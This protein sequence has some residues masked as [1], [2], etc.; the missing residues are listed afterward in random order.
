MNGTQRSRDIFNARLQEINNVIQFDE[1]KNKVGSE[2]A[3]AQTMMLPRSTLR[4]ASQRISTA[5]MPPELTFLLHS[6]TGLEFLH[7]L[8]VCTEFVI[9]QIAG[10]GIRVVQEFYDLLGIS[11]LIAT[12]IGSLQGRIASMENHIIEF[13][14]QQ[15]TSLAAQ[16]GDQIISLC[17]D[18]TY[19]DQ[20]CLVAIEPVSNFI[21]LES[22]SNKQD[23]ATWREHLQPRLSALNTTVFQTVGDEGS[24]LKS[25]A[26]NDLQAHHS[27]DLFHILQDVGRALGQ[28]FVKIAARLKK[29]YWRPKSIPK[30]L[31]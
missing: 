4:R 9:T 10:A 3:A 24:G 6:E 29:T 21:V 7:R 30:P 14:S 16:S 31:K 27:P 19:P 23:R 1:Y 17:L 8:V 25:F 15:E 5:H 26:L 13:G 11:E 12:S 20:I 18:E 22:L 28:S 2:R